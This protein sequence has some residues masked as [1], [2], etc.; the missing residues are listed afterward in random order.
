M[1]LPNHL[2]LFISGSL[3]TIGGN[4]ILGFINYLIRRTMANQ[5]SATDY[6][7]FFGAFSLLAILLAFLD[8][9]VIN[10]GTLLIAEQQEKK[11]EIFSFIFLL[12]LLSGLLVATVLFLLRNFI[13]VS[14]LGGNGSAMFGILAFFVLFNSLDGAFVAYYCGNKFYQTGNFF[15]CA[16]AFTLLILVYLLTQEFAA[17]GAAAAYLLAY[18][19]F[20]PLQLTWV[21]CNGKFRLTAKIPFETEKRFLALIGILAIITCMQTLLFNMDSVMLTW[22]CG[23]ETTAAYNVALPITQLLL[24]ILVFASVFLPI[25][26]DLVK[27][28]EF[29]RLRNYVIAALSCTLATLPCVFWGSRWF[30][31]FLVALLFKDSYVHSAVPVLPWLMSAYLL[32]SLGSFV[33]QILIAMRCIGLLLGISCLI[34]ISNFIMNY[35]LIQA[36]GSS[37]AAMATFTSYLFFAILSVIC[38]LWKSEKTN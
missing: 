36:Y 18:A 15:R 10:A 31:D 30:G 34:V 27:Q 24:A 19:I 12:K 1:R 22:L 7:C 8:L 32:F 29:E 23:P 20:C 26:T 9:G 11:G 33:T 5:L 17:A 37:G 21:C 6:G 3:I 13:A 38:F 16:I 2:R 35:Y 4:V 25:A 28:R 14:Y